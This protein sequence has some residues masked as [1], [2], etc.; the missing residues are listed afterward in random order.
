MLPYSN[1]QCSIA[2]PFFPTTMTPLSPLQP[3]PPCSKQMTLEPPTYS[4]SAAVPTYSESPG[5]SERTLAVSARSW[6]RTPTG[7]WIRSNNL[8]TIA[9]RGQEENAVQPSFSRGST[10]WGDIALG[11]TLG[12]QSISIKVSATSRSYAGLLTVSYL[13]GRTI[14][15][16]RPAWRKRKYL[17]RQHVISCWESR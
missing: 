13:G 15:T 6:R 7:I 3:L 5:P 17:V 4:P 8:I 16:G 1:S 10:V 14:A 11:C 9:L 2:Y 12:V